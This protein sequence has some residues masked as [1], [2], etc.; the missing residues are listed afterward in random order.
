MPTVTQT[1]MQTERTI[2]TALVAEAALDEASFAGLRER[3]AGPLAVVASGG[4][5]PGALLWA[6]LHAAS[7]YPAWPMT[8]H[9]LI[10]QGV[11]AGARV[12]LL[13]SGARHHDILRVARH[14]AAAGWPMSAVTCSPGAPLAGIVREA[15]ASEE[16]VLELQA[17]LHADPFLPVHGTIPI[18]L[19]AAH[20]Y[21]GSGP[22]APCFE[23]QPEAVPAGRPRALAALGAGV[24]A[25]AALD[26]AVKAQESGL[27]S[28][29]ST[30]V[31][32]VSHGQLVAIAR[33]PEEGLVVVF[34]AAAQ[35]AY[36]DRWT[37]CLPPSL[38]VLRLEV[39]G[40]GPG[41]ALA[42]MARGL[43]TF[44]A[45]AVAAGHPLG[46][47]HVPRWVMDIYGLEV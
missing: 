47:E 43:R 8:P 22:F 5:T 46:F 33:A 20:F 35:R 11:P 2:E 45:L 13:S 15:A 32:N 3:I 26:L 44:E 18:L 14:A 23:M 36:L 27:C 34:G 29:F 17:P 25:P 37:G 19:M 4:G 21:G 38:P 1:V 9:E 16:A 42:L 10:E 39:D 30:D 28:A 40:A 41:A 31:R 12:L 7:G 6:Q 24:A